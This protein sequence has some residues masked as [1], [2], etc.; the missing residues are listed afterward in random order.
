[1]SPQILAQL[2]E[3]LGRLAPKGFMFGLHIRFSRPVRRV[4]TYPSRWIQAYTRLNLGVGDPVMI[5]CMLNEGQIR[6]SDLAATATD[7]LGV[8]ARAADHGMTFG[9]ALSHGPVES[10]SYIGAAH[11]EREFT[12]AEIVAM[13]NILRQA[14]QI[15]DR[16]TALRP[17]LVEALDAIACGMT[18]EQASAALGI[19]RTA[20]RYRLQA[21]R[22]A[23]GCED[24]AMAIRRAIDAG[25]LNGNTI[26][27]L[28][29]GLPQGPVR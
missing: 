6:W 17:I 22:T 27:G 2:D 21:A 29:K 25:L 28:S 10:R 18:Y 8:M 19:S 23:L 11:D 16:T 15:L 26:G 14:H 4:C 3:E 5:W 20:L 12:D 7:P 1:M 9:V 13:S 24:N